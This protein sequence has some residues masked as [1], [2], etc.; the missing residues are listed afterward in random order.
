MNVYWSDEVFVNEIKIFFLVLVNNALINLKRK[1]C[2]LLWYFYILNDCEW[3]DNK[4]DGVG[5]KLK[6]NTCLTES[7]SCYKKKKNVSSD[8]AHAKGWWEAEKKM[9]ERKEE[10]QWWWD[11]G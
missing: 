7:G 11:Q 4:E 5:I 1:K 6:P 2:S 9:E 3:D 8:M 10:R